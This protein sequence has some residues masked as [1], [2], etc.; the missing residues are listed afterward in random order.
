[1]SP[2]WLPCSGSGRC[3]ERHWAPVVPPLIELP[4]QHRNEG[5]KK[6]VEQLVTWA[7]KTK[8]KT[9]LVMALWFADLRARELVTNRSGKFAKS[10]LENPYISEYR[11][12]QRRVISLTDYRAHTA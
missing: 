4:G 6:L 3:A 1:V 7:P 10:H 5:V 8:N 12:S 2:P 9:D 11:R